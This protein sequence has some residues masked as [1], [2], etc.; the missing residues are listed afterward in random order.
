MTPEQA[1]VALLAYFSRTKLND[2]QTAI[3]VSK[4]RALK[5]EQLERACS[6]AIDKHKYKTIPSVAELLAWGQGR[7]PGRARSRQKHV[8]DRANLEY[9]RLL[10]DPTV[11]HSALAARTTARFEAIRRAQ[12]R[13][14][15][16]SHFQDLDVELDLRGLDWNGEPREERHRMAHEIGRDVNPAGGVE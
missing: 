16:Q 3:Y 9:A 13:P 1:L 15:L 8:W 2:A 7:E 14:V 11:D 6:D 12:D 4:L 5:P 10:R